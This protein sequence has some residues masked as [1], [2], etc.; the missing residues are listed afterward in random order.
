MK[1]QL[2]SD[3]DLTIV[4]KGGG[5]VIVPNNTDTSTDK[6]FAT[7]DQISPG[8]GPHASTHATT[9]SDPITPDSIGA[10]RKISNSG[11]SLDWDNSNNLILS[12]SYLQIGD[13]VY[14]DGSVYTS[15]QYQ[16]TWQDATG[17]VAHLDDIPNVPIKVV[18]RNSTALTPDAQGAVNVVVP[19]KASEV[20]AMP[21]SYTG[22]NIVLFEL[23]PT[24]ATAVNS[25]NDGF[26]NTIASIAAA[27]S[28]SA[29]YA[30]GSYCT[31]EGT[32]YK[33]VTAVSTPG[34]WTGDANWEKV[35]V[36]DEMA[37]IGYVDSK[38]GDINSVLDAING[39]EI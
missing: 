14:D 34:A 19:T 38:I 35:T 12:G 37:T 3:E 13:T 18:K 27:F 31:R 7:V 17:I 5:N 6:T 25:V 22:E 1:I 26:R 33:C 16:H 39:E 21:E 9:G 8:G 20:G 15:G 36:T 24:I 10:L 28:K 2:K 23:G 29:T 4:T 11:S 32:L 30:V